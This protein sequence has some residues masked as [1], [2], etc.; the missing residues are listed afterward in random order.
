MENNCQC[1]L[2]E[3]I[4]LDERADSRQKTKD[5]MNIL[6]LSRI[7][8][9]CLFVFMCFICVSN[10]VSIN[11]MLLL[12][13]VF[14]CIILFGKKRW[15]SIQSG[16]GVE[17]TWLFMMILSM[18]QVVSYHLAYDST[19]GPFYDDSF[20]FNYACNIAQYGISSEG[21]F[22]LY[23]F[24]LAGLMRF[25]NLFGIQDINALSLLP[26]N[27]FCAALSVGFVNDLFADYEQKDVR[28]INN[29][30]FSMLAFIV[31]ATNTIYVDTTINLYRD[32][33]LI[34]LSILSIK[35]CFNHRYVL[36]F[37]LLIP[38]FFI[39]SANALFLF[40]LLIAIICSS[41]MKIV[42][43]SVSVLMPAVLVIVLI[44]YI[45][46][47]HLNFSFRNIA[48]KDVDS[49]SS[50]LD[51]RYERFGSFQYNLMVL[52]GRIFLPMRWVPPTTDDY[53]I[54]Q[55]NSIEYYK[56]YVVYYSA[57]TLFRVDF[58]LFALSIPLWVLTLAPIL[59]G[60]VFTLRGE[61][62]LQLISVYIVLLAVLTCLI[63][64]QT[65]H[66]CLYMCMFPFLLAAYN[67]FKTPKIEEQCKL[68]NFLVAFIIILLNF[69]ALF[70]LEGSGSAI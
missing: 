69:V 39:R 44:G 70:F 22:E 9:V 38:C 3:N 49:F 55:S 25:L 4:V 24:V 59:Y 46:I 58:L 11:G 27:C 23:S 66:K 10:R 67:R 36:A 15:F 52:P 2:T 50:R 20:Y 26:F 12:W 28:G 64:M 31:L 48:D 65:R 37:L 32:I 56:P 7:I 40:L 42:H 16:L 45:A 35:F 68:L 54:T 61:I 6:H 14:S 5:V 47:S 19:F 43:L 51:K 63:S 13:I 30:D 41:S 57:R 60:M 53:E 33:V 62:K 1:L 18:I 29:P 8:L 21:E 17:I 34:L